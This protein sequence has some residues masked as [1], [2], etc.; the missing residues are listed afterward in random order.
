MAK[1]NMP[2]DYPSARDDKEMSG[3]LKRTRFLTNLCQPMN[4]KFAYGVL[5]LLWEDSYSACLRCQ[6][7][8]II[9]QTLEH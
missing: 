6:K 4:E 2:I 9:G 5:Y 7:L 3:N 8:N 1:D